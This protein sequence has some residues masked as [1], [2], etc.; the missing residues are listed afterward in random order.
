MADS[1]NNPVPDG[2]TINFTTEGGFIQ[3]SCNTVNGSCRVIWTGTN[4]RV[5]NHR[6]TILATAIGHETFFDVNGNNVFDDADTPQGTADIHDQ[7]TDNGLTRGEY[8]DGGFVDHSEAWRDDDEDGER[9]TKEIFID[10][11]N[12]NT[13]N[14][15]DRKFNGPHCLHSTMCGGE[16]ASKINVR[17]GLVMIMSGS[18]VAYTLMTDVLTSGSNSSLGHIGIRHVINSNDNGYTIDNSEND[19]EKDTNVVING[20]ITIDSAGVATSNNENRLI[21]EESQSLSMTLAVADRAIGLGQTL[22]AGTIITIQSN[23]GTIDGAAS[24]VIPNR[25]GASDTK[26]YGGNGIAFT[27]V[28][29]NSVNTT[30]NITSTGFITITFS[31][32]SSLTS[33]V[34]TIPYTLIGR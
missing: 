23:S 20:G 21:L 9:Q 14:Q 17:K 19:P 32:P 22:P 34:F 11:N 10:Y 15:A 3:P 28:N 31:Y 24:S 4:P 5:D 2:T 27:L 1:F 6:I 13:F 16:N 30:G 33:E 25:K 7:N 12:D 18:S 8:K 29:T 26:S